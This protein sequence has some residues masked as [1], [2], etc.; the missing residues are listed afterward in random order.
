MKLA[1]FLKPSL[2]LLILLLASA[3]EQS[4]K[5]PPPIAYADKDTHT[6]QHEDQ[7]L[8]TFLDET[9]ERDVSESPERQARLG[10]KTDDYGKWNDYSEAF[11]EY[12]YKQKQTDLERLHNEFKHFKQANS[13]QRLLA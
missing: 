12:K 10:R 2:S 4:A 9:F 3:C 6:R 8:A 7:R 13:I 5:S 1:S 11:S